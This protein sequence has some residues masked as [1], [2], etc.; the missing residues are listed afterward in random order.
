MSSLGLCFALFI[1]GTG[2]GDGE[3]DN[4]KTP[5]GT[6][7]LTPKK[8]KDQETGNLARQEI[9]RHKCLCTPAK[10]HRGKNAVPTPSPAAK[11][12][13]GADLD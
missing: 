5:M 11:A 7:K 8:A 3:A 4:L 1:L 13:R 12:R 2:G 6:D 10:H 9:F